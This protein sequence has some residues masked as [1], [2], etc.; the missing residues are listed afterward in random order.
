M[1]CRFC[2]LSAFASIL[3]FTAAPASAC[4]VVGHRNGEPVCMTTSDGKGQQYTDARND[5]PVKVIKALA[6]LRIKQAQQA[7]QAQPANRCPPNF[8]LTRTNQC[9][10]DGQCRPGRVLSRTGQCV[11]G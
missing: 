10:P 3:A 8:V 5:R 9:A 1:N 4:K 11:L 6:H 7:Q 2:V